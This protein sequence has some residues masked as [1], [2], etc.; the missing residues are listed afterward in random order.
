MPSEEESVAPG[1]PPD[2]SEAPTGLTGLEHTVLGERGARNRDLFIQC[3]FHGK[4]QAYEAVLQ[5]LEG[6][7]DWSE[8]SQPIANEVFLKHQ[9]NIYSPPAVTFTEAVE[10]RFCT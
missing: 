2:S 7:R 9:V 8:A 1:V 10:A 3:L 4:E 5:R 6:A